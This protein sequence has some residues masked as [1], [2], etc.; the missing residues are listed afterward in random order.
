MLDAFTLNNIWNKVWPR[1]KS[2]VLWIVLHLCT[3]M[4]CGP[5]LFLVPIN[6]YSGSGSCST[7]QTSFSPSGCTLSNCLCIENSF[8]I[9]ALQTITGVHP[10]VSSVAPNPLP[11]II[12]WGSG[13]EGAIVLWCM[14]CRCAGGFCYYAA[15]V[16]STRI[17]VHLSASPVI[18]ARAM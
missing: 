11:P 2:F 14:Q 9:W 18:T 16:G 17:R 13:A 1:I 15:C 8:P 10:L 5:M 12:S 6:I 7:R 4:Q 3:H